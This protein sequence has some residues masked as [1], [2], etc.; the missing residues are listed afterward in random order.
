MKIWIYWLSL[1]GAIASSAI[2]LFWIVFIAFGIRHVYTRA[3]KPTSLMIDNVGC[4]IILII[5]ASA[6]W[7]AVI[8]L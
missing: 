2:L 3:S 7:S 4:F 6:F 1:T 8:L 5:I